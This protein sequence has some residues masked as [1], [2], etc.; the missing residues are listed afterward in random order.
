[1]EWALQSLKLP[2]AVLPLPLCHTPLSPA[3]VTAAP[4]A[5]HSSSSTPLA[6][7]MSTSCKNLSQDLASAPSGVTPLGNCE[8]KLVSH[9]QIPDGTRESPSQGLPQMQG[10]LQ[11]L[12]PALL[13]P[14]VAFK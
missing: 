10:S 12:D 13:H 11:E 2:A 5:T 6:S 3:A 14:P 1:M 8:I 4:M 7:P 9:E